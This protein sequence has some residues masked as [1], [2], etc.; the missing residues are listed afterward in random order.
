MRILDVVCN[1]NPC[2]YLYHYEM[3]FFPL[4]WDWVFQL[5]SY[6]NRLKFKK[7][8]FLVIHKG[9][10]ITSTNGQVQTTTTQTGIC[11]NNPCK[12][13]AQCIP[14][15]NSAFTCNYRDNNF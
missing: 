11:G 3:D 4:D 9:N 14:S 8:N 13:G 15:G 6:K 2:S 5:D 7:I 1:P 12:N 10:S